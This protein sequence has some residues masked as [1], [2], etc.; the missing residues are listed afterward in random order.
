MFLH[1][2]VC[3]ALHYIASVIHWQGTNVP[4]TFAKDMYAFINCHIFHG[5]FSAFLVCLLR[6]L[7]GLDELG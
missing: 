7:H 6:E 3:I 2:F 5:T 1:L 4:H